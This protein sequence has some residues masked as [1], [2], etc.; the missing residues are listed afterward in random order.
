MNP[1]LKYYDLLI[2]FLNK[3]EIK[4]EIFNADSLSPYL[5]FEFRDSIYKLQLELR[6]S[7]EC[8]IIVDNIITN[9]LPINKKTDIELFNYFKKKVE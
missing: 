9:K 4:Y 6:D 1:F 7:L 3:K 5:V 2:S 8:M